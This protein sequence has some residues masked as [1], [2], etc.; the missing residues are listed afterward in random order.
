MV[1]CFNYQQTCV[2]K[3]IIRLLLILAIKDQLMVVICYLCSIVTYVVG[4]QVREDSFVIRTFLHLI[5]C[6]V[7]MVK[8]FLF[9]FILLLLFRVY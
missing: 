4:I 3:K 2:R 1:I 6:I 7:H 9:Y 8:F 5:Q